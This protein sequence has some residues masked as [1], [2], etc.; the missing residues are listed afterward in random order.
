MHVQERIHKRVILLIEFYNTFKRWPK[1]TESFHGVKLGYFACRVKYNRTPIS[2]EDKITLDKL[3]FFLINSSSSKSTK[4]CHDKIILLKEYYETFSRW[5]KQNEIYKGE[6]IGYFFSNVKNRF[7]TLSDLDKEILLNY[8]FS[9]LNNLAQNRIHARVLLITEF[10]NIFNRLPLP[11]E[12]FK[13]IEIG[14]F[15]D[16]IKKNEIPLSDKDIEMLE[17]INFFE[18]VSL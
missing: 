3:N 7:A 14:I 8:G 5:P 1:Y 9:P 11:N 6:K 4:S 10:Y 2:D 13:E 18:E 15:T 12:K 16:K 17:K